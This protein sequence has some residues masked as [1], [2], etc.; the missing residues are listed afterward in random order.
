M[1]GSISGG[2][3]ESDVREVALAALREG[4]AR[5]RTYETGADEN[6][7]WGLG[8]GCAGSVELFVQ[9]VDAAAL[10][11]IARTRELFAEGRPFAIAT[12]IGGSAPA[13]GSVVASSGG[14]TW[15]STG[16]PALDAEIARRASEWIAGPS[17]R[18]VAVAP[19]EV[20]VQLLVPPP[21]LLLFGADEDAKP[22][23]TF[24]SSVGFRVT[25]V[26]HREAL[27]GPARF[28]DAERRLVGRPEDGV[29]GLGVGP[30]TFA[31]V[32]THRIAHDR[33]WARQLLAAGAGYVG[34]LGPRA[35]TREIR[36]SIGAENDPRVFGPVGLDL[37][38]EGPDQVAFSIV[39][40]LLAASSGV[41]PRPLREKEDRVH[42]S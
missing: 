38:A 3:L 17:S 33:E 5:R 15:G 13:G 39:A 14:E 4:T 18:T 35:R 36:R 30:R 23:T 29:A 7:A 24:A 37:G 10:H 26:D 12:V 9:P 16:D 28:P 40:E 21:S 20:F 22:I 42:A 8:L 1:L 31:V 25:V 11:A 27:L 32:K 6:E 34:L 19:A 2:C 41:A